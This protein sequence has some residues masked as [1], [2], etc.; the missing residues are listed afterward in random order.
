M[1]STISPTHVRATAKVRPKTAGRPLQ[2]S[3]FQ[4]LKY[5]LKQL[6]EAN[7]LYKL[8]HQ[9]IITEHLATIS[10]LTT[11]LS[12]FRTEE[13]LRT[14]QLLLPMPH[15]TPYAMF[16]VDVINPSN[17]FGPETSMRIC[18]CDLW[19]HTFYAGG[20]DVGCDRVSSSSGHM[21]SR[22]LL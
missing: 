8:T 7:H 5:G 18:Q 12:K 3:V 9:A 4:T 13:K 14:S 1:V 22:N 19:T 15:A 16:C 21:S 10:L 11:R 2:P 17:A 6:D 20:V